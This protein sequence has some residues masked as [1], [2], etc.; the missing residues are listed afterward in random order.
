MLLSAPYVTRKL[1]GDDHVLFVVDNPYAK[2]VLA[3]GEGNI[4]PVLLKDASAAI[5]LKHSVTNDDGSETTCS[6]NG[7]TKFEDRIQNV[8]P[9]LHD[10]DDSTYNDRAIL[11]AT[12]DNIENIND[13]ILNKIA[14]PC[15]S[16]AQ[17]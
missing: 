8:Y 15:S 16:P 9:D 10:V 1:G 13:F 7:T 5:P 3:I 12:N 14:R 11:A 4:K 6:V 2:T 17:F